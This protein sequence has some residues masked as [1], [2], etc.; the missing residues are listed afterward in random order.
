MV[1]WTRL[2]PK[3]LEGGGM[4]DLAVEVDW[5][6]A[7]DEGMKKVVKKGTAMATPALGHSVHVEVA[8]LQPD[9]WYW[10]QFRAG[11]EMSPVGR[12]RTAPAAGAMPDRLK[13]AFASCQH[14][15]TGFFTAYEHMA[16]EKIGRAHV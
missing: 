8:G 1:L 9:R 5:R 11:K 6:L 16:A 2:A 14:W 4:P 15:E 12:T 3:P 10:Y 7:E 13:Y